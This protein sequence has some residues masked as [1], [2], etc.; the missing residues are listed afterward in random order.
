MR[1]DRTSER[2]RRFGSR[3]G[4]RGTRARGRPSRRVVEAQAEEARDRLGPEAR[5]RR[6]VG[7]ACGDPDSSG[8]GEKPECADELRIELAHRDELRR[9]GRSRSGLAP[10]DE[11][12]GELAAGQRIGRPEA[13][14]AVAEDPDRRDG[15]NL[16]VGPRA[17]RRGRDG[18]RR[19]RRRRAG[20]HCLRPR[21]PQRGRRAWSRSGRE[22]ASCSLYRPH[23]TGLEREADESPPGRRSRAVCAGRF[24]PWDGIHRS[25]V[26]DDPARRPRRSRSPSARASSSTAPTWRS[27]RM[28]GSASSGR[29]AAA[30]RRC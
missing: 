2:E 27:S 3:R 30:S 7:I 1:R 17:R 16:R 19:R 28:P 11:R 24:R 26:R 5:R 4:L 10:R 9:I 23:P 13:G 20:L 15:S 22:R 18:G 29:T 6:Q 14:N 8:G 12:V 21:L 25:S